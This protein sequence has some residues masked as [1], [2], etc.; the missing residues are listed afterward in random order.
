MQPWKTN[1]VVYGFSSGP[2]NAPFQVFCQLVDATKIKSRILNLTVKYKSTSH[3]SPTSLWNINLRTCA[4]PQPA[5]FTRRRN[6]LEKHELWHN[7]P[8]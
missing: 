5:V 3:D 8:Q 1:N 4:A 7:I 6:L 2:W